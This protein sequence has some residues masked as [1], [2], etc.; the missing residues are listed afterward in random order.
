VSRSA[1]GGPIQLFAKGGG[2]PNSWTLSSHLVTKSGQSVNGTQISAFLHTHC[3][4]FG[5]PPSP[6]P[7][8]GIAKVIGPSAGRACLGHVA[9]TFDMLVTYQPASRY[10]TFQWLE[11]GIFLALAAAAAI[12]CYFW[13]T[14]RAN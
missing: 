8:G 3:P 6:P 14:R 12:A 5:L 4:H 13:V 1:N 2:P 11:A 10:W 9:K 7:G